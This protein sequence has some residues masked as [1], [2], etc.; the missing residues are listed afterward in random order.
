MC[1]GIPPVYKVGQTQPIEPNGIYDSIKEDWV[2]LVQ[3]L[4]RIPV[5]H[6]PAGYT[7]DPDILSRSFY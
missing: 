5:E 2:R 4:D 6:M 1:D 3:H 7:V